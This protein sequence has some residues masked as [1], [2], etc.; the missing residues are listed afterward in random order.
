MIGLQ[1]QSSVVETRS[2]KSNDFDE[3]PKMERQR[4]FMFQSLFGLLGLLCRWRVRACHR[5]HALYK[6]RYPVNVLTSSTYIFF[7]FL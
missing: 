3:G 1:Q 6:H 4:S 5:G 7:W 2:P